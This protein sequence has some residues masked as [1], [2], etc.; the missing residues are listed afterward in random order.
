MN[1]TIGSE[2][3]GSAQLSTAMVKIRNLKKFDENIF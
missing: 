2:F 1:F 3:E